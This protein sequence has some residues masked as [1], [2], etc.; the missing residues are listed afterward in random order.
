MKELLHSL[1][2]LLTIVQKTPTFGFALPA[3][4]FHCSTAGG[5]DTRSRA[6]FTSTTIKLDSLVKLPQQHLLLVV[7]FIRGGGQKLVSPQTSRDSFQIHSDAPAVLEPDL[8]T[9]GSRISTE[10]MDR[11]LA[12]DT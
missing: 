4:S 3:H 8:A 2:Q 11:L 1:E 10:K 12:G 6:L 9:D 7:D 5:C